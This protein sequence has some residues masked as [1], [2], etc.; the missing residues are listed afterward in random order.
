M[1]LMVQLK[2][3]PKLSLAT[4]HSGGMECPTHSYQSVASASIPII[5]RPTIQN[6]PSRTT[7]ARGQHHNIIIL[8]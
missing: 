1:L 4:D 3:M 8:C 7:A 2:M 6:D 5:V